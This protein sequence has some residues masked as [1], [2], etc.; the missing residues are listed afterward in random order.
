VTNQR[1]VYTEL[2]GTED[3]TPPLIL[4]EGRIL[5]TEHL[6]VPSER[7]GKLLFLATEALPGENI[8]TEKRVTLEIGVLA[9]EV[10]SWDG[11]DEND[12]FRHPS[13]PKRL[14]RRALVTDELVPGSLVLIRQKRTFRKLDRGNVVEEGQLLGIINPALAV[15]EMGTKL[16]K[17]DA[18]AADV[19]AAAELKRES[20]E[21]LSGIDR[22]LAKY[23]RAISREERGTA[24]AT[25]AKYREEEVS[26][27]AGVVQAQRE[28]STALTQFNM[29]LIRA[30]IGGVIKFVHKQNGESVKNLEA[31]LQLHNP[32]RLLVEAQVEVQ[33]ALPLH[34]R[35]KKARALRQ[36]ATRLRAEAQ[37]RGLPEPESV[38]RLQRESDQ[39]LSVRVEASRVEQ[40]LAALS[41]HHQ[42][43]TCVAVTRELQ[44]R[45]VSGSEDHTV[46]LWN[47][48]PGSDRWQ[49]RGRLDH[50]AVVRALACTAPTAKSNLLL[51]GTV[52]GEGR[53]FDLDNLKTRERF[54]QGRHSGAI[55]AVA[56]SP[57]GTLCATGGE[58]RSI[59]LWE[60]SEGQLLDKVTSAHGQGVTSLA[61]TV[62]GQLVSA[63]RD[64]R[65][66]LWN[67]AEGGKTLKKAGAFDRRSGDVAQLGVDP[68]GEHV[69]FD[70]G[71]ELRSLSLSTRKI[72]GTLPNASATESFSTM[73]LFS[74][75]GNTILTNGNGPGR[76]QLWRA[77]TAKARPAELRQY[78][79]SSGMVTCGTFSPDGNLAIT[80]TQD[81]RVLV[82]Q[83]PS[84]TERETSSIGELAYVEEFLDTSLKRLTVRATLKNPGWIIPGSS[85]TIVV[86]P[87]GR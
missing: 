75:D 11:V 46:R 42:E 52:L 77:P 70:E 49:E 47:R 2:A 3:E 61:F 33:D 84:K 76:L 9:I 63:G 45:I 25:L 40:P 55:N 16:A 71:R 79:W 20:A 14:F 6:D 10:A 69:L 17:L 41:G 48:I 35:L 23:A 64:K 68:S 67:L 80:G 44:P 22:V 50:H 56:F 36:Q 59:C 66:V 38:P 24:V 39:L 81:A 73:A 15:D 43:V 19:R 62:R 8:P 51:T 86:P 29:H 18:A 54:L 78:A 32:E 7:D 57:N 27:R 74:P 13:D 72:E 83:I 5:T 58:D 85:A 82:W 87:L 21:K 4:R 65:L 60:T 12:R 28:L 34:A 37:R 31:V 1:A 30:P 53:L 26:K